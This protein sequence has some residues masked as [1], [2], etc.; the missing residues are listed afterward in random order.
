MNISKKK[1]NG[2]KIESFRKLWEKQYKMSLTPQG[3]ILKCC[4]ILY[5]LQFFQLGARFK[6]KIIEIV[7]WP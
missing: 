3:T 5:S 6:L 7:T 2:P 1:E 4:E